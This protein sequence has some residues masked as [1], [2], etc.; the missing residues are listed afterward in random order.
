MDLIEGYT[1]KKKK[2]R[3][4]QREKEGEKHHSL[5]IVM[6]RERSADREIK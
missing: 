2:K 4:K 1:R 5:S 3:A 6:K